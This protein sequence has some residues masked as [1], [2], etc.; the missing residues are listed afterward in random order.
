VNDNYQ[1]RYCGK[2][3]TRFTATLDHVKPVAEGGD[4]SFENLVTAWGF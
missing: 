3:R 2:H 4:H 1:C